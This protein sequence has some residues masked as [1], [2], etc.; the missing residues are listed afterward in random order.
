MGMRI[1]TAIGWGMPFD[2]FVG[3]LRLADPGDPLGD[4]WSDHLEATLGHT[5]SMRGPRGWP[6]PITGPNETVADLVIHVGHDDTTDVIL[7]PSIGEARTWHRRDD[8]L[9]YALIWGPRGPRDRE[10][11]EN[12]VE[13]LTRGLH[14]YGDLRMDSRGREMPRLD[15]WD[16]DRALARETDGTSLPGVP[17]TLRHWLA[18]S[19]MLDDE[20][21]AALRPVRAVWWA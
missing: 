11:P 1:N 12:R 2:R 10:V 3:L 9:D 18:V 6:L 13:Y 20:G 19:K 16:V 15:P 8:D 14:P 17:P 7:M 5:R 4:G 21:V